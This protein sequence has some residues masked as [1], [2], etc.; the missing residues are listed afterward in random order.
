MATTPQRK[1]M[2]TA[3]SFFRLGFFNSFRK[4]L[5]AAWTILK[6]QAG[7]ATEITYVKTETGEIRNAK[8]LQV[9]SLSTLVDGYVRYMEEINDRF[10][11][12]SFRIAHLVF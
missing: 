12:R 8:A 1:A 3:W 10:Q 4:A 5:K 11:W 9:G 2:T 6:I 7:I